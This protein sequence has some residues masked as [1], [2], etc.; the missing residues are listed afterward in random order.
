MTSLRLAQVYAPGMVDVTFDGPRRFTIAIGDPGSRTLDSK[1][2]GVCYWRLV[3]TQK[4]QLLTVDLLR[5]SG[6]L[7]GVELGVYR[8]NARTN[9]SRVALPDRRLTGVPMFDLTSWFDVVRGPN[10]IDVWKPFVVVLWQDALE[11]VIT[12]AD[13]ATSAVEVNT[14][15][16]CLFDDQQRLR[17]FVLRGM[18]P[19]DRQRYV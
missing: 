7:F 18:K 8:G 13:A 2:E 14:Q 9:D 6:R 4:E 1:Q 3:G 15:F 16:V 12:E 19:E 10:L 17:S 5:K 11:I